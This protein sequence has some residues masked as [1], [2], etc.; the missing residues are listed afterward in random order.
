M[1]CLKFLESVALHLAGCE[2]V[3]AYTLATCV[4]HPQLDEPTFNHA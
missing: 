3:V 2:P 1:S 4:F